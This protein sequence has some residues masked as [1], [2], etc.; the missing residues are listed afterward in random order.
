MTQ[1]LDWF[2][3]EVPLEDVRHNDTP[4]YVREGHGG[5][6][7][8]AWPIY[9]FFKAY[10]EGLQDVARGEFARWYR[11]RLLKYMDVPGEL[12]G[13]YKGSLYRLI[14]A[15]HS[16]SGAELNG[17]LQNAREEIVAKCIEQRVEQSFSLVDAIRRD[18]YLLERAGRVIAV[19]QRRG[20]Y[21]KGGHHRAAILKVL[22][23]ETFPGLVVLPKALFGL[24][25]R[26]TAARASRQ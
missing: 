11:D 2:A 14:E 7:I 6:A 19:R 9:A 10:S 8:A 26:V 18:G 16:A 24:V 21:L 4:V 3:R 12:G 17:S 20:I 25:H 5:Q 22:G 13:M 1:V 23:Y 15:S